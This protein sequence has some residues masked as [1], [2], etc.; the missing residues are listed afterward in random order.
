[1]EFSNC[2]RIKTEPLDDVLDIKDESIAADLE[3]LQEVESMEVVYQ[4]VPAEMKIE[5]NADNIVEQEQSCSA[6]AVPIK[7]DNFSCQI[8][9]KDCFVKLKNIHVLGENVQ[10]MDR[11]SRRRCQHIYFIKQSNWV[12]FNS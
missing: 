5:V 3:D 7:E 2:A 9:T 10:G 8:R 6:S 4:D 12:K 1:M 11:L